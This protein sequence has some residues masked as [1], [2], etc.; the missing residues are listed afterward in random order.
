MVTPR[1]NDTAKT[2]SFNA[3]QS[4]ARP[5]SDCGYW[6]HTLPNICQLWSRHVHTVGVSNNVLD[7]VDVVNTMNLQNCSYFCNSLGRVDV[8]PSA[9]DHLEPL[10]AP[11]CTCTESPVNGRLECLAALCSTNQVN[12]FVDAE[13]ARCGTTALSGASSM[14]ISTVTSSTSSSHRN[15]NFYKP[16][17]DDTREHV[18]VE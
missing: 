5:S 6:E 4:F 14:P 13:L 3:H 10:I 8:P 7:T 18:T 17:H 1:G 11:G 12:V 16:A 9:C 15:F 2:V